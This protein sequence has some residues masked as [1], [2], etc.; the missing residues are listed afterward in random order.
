MQKITA[1][2]ALL[3]PLSPSLSTVPASS[4]H[5][6][7][8]SHSRFAISRQKYWLKITEALCTW[9][10]QTCWGQCFSPSWSFFPWFRSL[11][12]LKHCLHGHRGKGIQLRK[13]TYVHFEVSCQKALASNKKKTVV[14]EMFNQTKFFTASVPIFPLPDDSGYDTHKQQHDLTNRS[15]IPLLSKSSVQQS[16]IPN[17]KLIY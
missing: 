5:N 1:R 12:K 7:Q 4:C 6:N 13:F 10:S 9:L 17:S 2:A 15:G 8:L 16:E 14:S 11:G 3:T